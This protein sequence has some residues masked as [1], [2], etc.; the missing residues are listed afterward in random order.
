M[1]L[2][3]LPLHKLLVCHVV[4][5]EY[6]IWKIMKLVLLLVSDIYTKFYGTV[7]YWFMN[8]WKGKGSTYNLVFPNQTV[9][10]RKEK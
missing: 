10:L 4:I 6:M 8:I 9:S 1:V 5:T 7:M 2:V 3:L